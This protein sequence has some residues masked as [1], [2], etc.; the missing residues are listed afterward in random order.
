MYVKP[1]CN[2]PCVRYNHQPRAVSS[3]ALRL[4]MRWRYTAKPQAPHPRP[5]RRKRT[6]RGDINRHEPETRELEPLR[7]DRDVQ[8]HARCRDGRLV[9]DDDPASQL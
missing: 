8:K 1:V 5:L 4:A 7:P 2:W 9:E 6:Q 3:A